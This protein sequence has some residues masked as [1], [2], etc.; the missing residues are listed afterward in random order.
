MADVLD[1]IAVRTGKKEE[2]IYYGYVAFFIRLS[3]VAVAIIFAVVHTLTGFTEG[4][5]T[6]AEL[7]SR[8]PTPELALLG[9]RFHTALIP[10]ILV[11]VCTLIFW[12]FYDLT[13]D[14]V[15]ANRAKLQQLN[16]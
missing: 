1:D 8:S 7:F 5:T 14:V 9:I 11:L 2:E 15:A 4:T 3:G 6:R 10:A 13:P 16:L 12:K